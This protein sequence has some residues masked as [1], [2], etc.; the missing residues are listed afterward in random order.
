MRYL[1]INVFILVIISSCSPAVTKGL[2]QQPPKKEYVVNDY[3]SNI[4]RDYVYKAKFQFLKHHFG[5]I[6]IIK[7]INENH[8]RVVFTTEFGNKLFDMEFEDGDFSVNFILD[9]LNRKFILKML[10]YDFQTLLNQNIKVSNQ[11]SNMEEDIFR[12]EGKEFQNYYVFSKGTGQLTKI[13]S[14]NRNK[15]KLIITFLVTDKDISTSINL[16]HKRFKAKMDL[17][18]IGQMD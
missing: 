11:Y 17:N 5:G 8:H 2:I 4:E 1:L 6:L 13:V 15:E 7:K 3:F 18:Y 9:K 12:S 10:Q 16:N 14:A